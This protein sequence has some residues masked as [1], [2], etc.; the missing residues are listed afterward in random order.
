M[1]KKACKYSYKDRQSIRKE[2]EITDGISLSDLLKTCSN[3][4]TARI[5]FDHYYDDPTVL[6]AWTVAETDEEM[7]AR[8][9]EYEEQL[10]AEKHKE[11]KRKQQLLAAEKQTYLRLKKKFEKKL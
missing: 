11:Q 7:A 6:L 10:A 2:H 9:A 8:I 4:P 5:D 1:A 3:N